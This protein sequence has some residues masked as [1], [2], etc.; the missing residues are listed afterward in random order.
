MTIPNFP[1]FEDF[2]RFRAF[3][4]RWAFARTGAAFRR[5]IL[6]A[7]E[8]IPSG[9]PR[10]H[11]DLGGI[12][13][14]LLLENAR[15]NNV[16]NP[17]FEG[18]TPGLM[19]GAGVMPT[20]MSHFYFSGAPSLTLNSITSE[21]GLPVAEFTYVATVSTDR[22][23]IRFEAPS[24][25]PL[26]G[27]VAHAHGFFARIVSGTPPA[28]FLNS[29][30]VDAVT[31]QNGTN[32]VTALTGSPIAE[33]RFVEVFTP[34]ADA[35]AGRSQLLMLGTANFTFR[36]G[37]PSLM[38]APYSGTP[39]LPAVGS[40]AASTRGAET[41]TATLAD[42][43]IPNGLT[44]GTIL[45]R[46]RAPAGVDPT[47][48]VIVDADDGTAANRIRCT[49]E[50]SRLIRTEIRQGGVVVATANTPGAADDDQD[51]RL[52]VA[53]SHTGVQM[54]I[55]GLAPVAL[56]PTAI[57]LLTRLVLGGWG[58]TVQQAAYSP[59]RISAAALQTLTA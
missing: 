19:G 33:S 55:N 44:Q 32:F 9:A 48:Q 36:L 11:H 42:W 57:P 22:T 27:A 37:M 56:A 52:A 47:A 26:G 17:R 8:L 16:R 7:W 18:A 23:D 40:P 14:G 41:L 1:I 31:A 49:R 5:T 25:S 6:G 35:T 10:I 15:T 54:I 38:T 58:G 30:R 24:G 34:L 43:G 45:F 53:W 59:R 13:L 12:C 51:L 21:G 39:F 20:N 50:T 4:S 28:S 46:G 29:L 3:D 2:T